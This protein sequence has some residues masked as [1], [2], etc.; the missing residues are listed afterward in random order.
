[1][2]SELMLLLVWKGLKAISFLRH[3]DDLDFATVFKKNLPK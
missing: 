1:M 3:P 2:V